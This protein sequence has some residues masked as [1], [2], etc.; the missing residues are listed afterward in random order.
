[1]SKT[2]QQPWSCRTAGLLLWQAYAS[3]GL[4]NRSLAA[5]RPLI[6]RFDRLL[7][8][9]PRDRRVLEIGCGNGLLLLLLHKCG[10]LREGLGIDINAAAIA[11]AQRAAQANRLPI[12][13]RQ[14][15]TPEDWPDERF[16]VV[17]LVDVLHHVP[18]PLRRPMIEAAL[19]RVAAGGLLIYKDMC[20]QPMLRR[21]WNQLHDIV[22]A[23]QLV[24]VEPIEHVLSWATAA[25]FI[26]VASERYVGAGL[27][28]HELEVLRRQTA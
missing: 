3:S 18:R 12:V 19:A 27:Y 15:A 8:L 14:C 17:L 13:F 21:L 20:R 24:S 26:S 4:A 1:V 10:S 7:P 22:L 6:A 11:G 25:G 2:R 23:R 16:D 28:G 9:V 5:L